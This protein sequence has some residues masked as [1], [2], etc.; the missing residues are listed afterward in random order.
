MRS[1]DVVAFSGFCLDAFGTAHPDVTFKKLGQEQGRRHKEMH[2]ARAEA[3]R[4][5]LCRSTH[6]WTRPLGCPN[7]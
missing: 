7:S 5:V 2:T 6:A 1:S 3:E 4:D